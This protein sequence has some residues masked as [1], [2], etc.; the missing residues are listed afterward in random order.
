MAAGAY[1]TVLGRPPAGSSAAQPQGLQQPQPATGGPDDDA[2]DDEDLQDLAAE[3]SDWTAD[4]SAWEA[5]VAAVT[6]K[7]VAHK[8]QAAGQR[9]GTP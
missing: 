3:E 5:D 4:Q 8:T 1:S 2:D 9:S 6:H 7:H